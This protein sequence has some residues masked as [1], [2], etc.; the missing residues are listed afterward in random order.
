LTAT[1]LGDG[2][3]LAATEGNGAVLAA[4]EGDGVALPPHAPTTIASADTNARGLIHARDLVMFLFLLL[5]TNA[6]H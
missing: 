5:D 1:G 2:A 4:T 3:V 6:D